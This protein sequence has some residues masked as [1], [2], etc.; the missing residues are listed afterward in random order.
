[1][2]KNICGVIL[3]GGESK[4]MGKGLDKAEI[5]LQNKPLLCHVVD[6]VTRVF[7]NILIVEDVLGHYEK[8]ISN[9]NNDSSI[10]WI[11][12]E[13]PFHGP[14]HGIHMACKEVCPQP[15]FVV[16]C[17]M[18]YLN[19]NLIRFVCQQYNGKSLAVVPRV[20]GKLQPLFALYNSPKMI[21]FLE[22]K[23]FFSLQQLFENKRSEIQIIEEREIQAQDPDLLSFRNL[24]S[25]RDFQE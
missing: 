20:Y 6:S 4:R 18:P 16:G 10:N 23:N 3:A 15:I 5:P 13:V 7:A 25:Q 8:L 12:D 24:N 9:A 2:E 17:D 14:L 19:E 22:E 11:C 1:M 21:Q